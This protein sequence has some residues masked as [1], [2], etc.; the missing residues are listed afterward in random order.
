MTSFVLFVFMTFPHFPSDSYGRHERVPVITF[1]F[2]FQATRPRRR[3][4]AWSCLTPTRCW[5]TNR[6]NSDGPPSCPI[7]RVSFPELLLK[8]ACAWLYHMLINFH[9]VSHGN[10]NSVVRSWI[11]RIFDFFFSCSYDLITHFQL[12][13]RGNNIHS[14][15]STSFFNFLK[16]SP[17]FIEKWTRETGILAKMCRHY[18]TALN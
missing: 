2:C 1:I 14:M 16:R 8:Y 13:F 5:F 9:R 12:P 4:C 18:S 17:L 15:V 10:S 6:R 11:M 7:I 3:P